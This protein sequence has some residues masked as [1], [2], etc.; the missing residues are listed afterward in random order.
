LTFIDPGINLH[1]ISN[2]NKLKNKVMKKFYVPF[3][4][5]LFSFFSY[6]CCEKNQVEGTW[7]LVSAKWSYSDT[8][9][10]EFPNSEYDR[11]VKMIGKTHFL[12]IRQDT[13]NKDLFFSGGGT[14]KLEGNRYTE[15]LDVASWGTDIGSVITYDCQFNDSMWIMTGP[16]NVEGEELPG[17]KLHEE[18]EKIE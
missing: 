17:W 1:P 16:V 12:F 5:I 9:V 6:S 13:T 15:T 7:E 10:V 4:V 3:I 2:N 11:E 14:Y 18:W 8:N